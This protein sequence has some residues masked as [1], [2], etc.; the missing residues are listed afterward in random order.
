MGWLRRSPDVVHG[1]G[2][3]L[4]AITRAGGITFRARSRSADRRKHDRL[5]LYDLTDIHAVHDR[6]RHLAPEMIALW[7]DAIAED[8][9]GPPPRLVVDIGCGTGRFTGA[10]ARRARIASSGR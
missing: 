2:P 3:I 4:A 9:P 7:L 1:V 10:L 5:H 8:L 6:S